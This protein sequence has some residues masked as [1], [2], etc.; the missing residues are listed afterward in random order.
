MPQADHIYLF[1]SIDDAREM[2]RASGL[3]VVD[4]DLFVSSFLHEAEDKANLQDAPEH[5]AVYACNVRK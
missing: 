5:A 3:E 4:Q 2:I 1:R